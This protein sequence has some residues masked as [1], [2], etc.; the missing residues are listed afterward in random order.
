MPGE[1]AEPPWLELRHAPTATAPAG[2]S[3]AAQPP[4][5]VT[6]RLGAHTVPGL[7]ERV[8][9]LD[10][11]TVVSTTRVRPPVDAGTGPVELRLE[12]WTRHPAAPTV[13]IFYRRRQPGSRLAAPLTRGS[14]RL[15]PS[16]IKEAKMT[17]PEATSVDGDVSGGPAMPAAAPAGISAT[18]DFG[19]SGAVAGVLDVRSVQRVD[20]G[21]LPA[22]SLARAESLLGLDQPDPAVDRALNIE[23][24]TRD[25]PLARAE[26][27]K[28]VFEGP[29][30]RFN[31]LKTGRHRSSDLV[32]DGERVD[33]A[34]EVTGVRLRHRGVK[35]F[36]ADLDHRLPNTRLSAREVFPRIYQRFADLTRDDVQLA[37][38]VP[39]IHV[40]F[41]TKLPP[42]RRAA[43]LDELRRH[44]LAPLIE[45][46]VDESAAAAGFFLMRRFGADALLGAEAFKLHARCP[47]GPRAWEDP[48]LW[49][50]A[51]QWHE[52]LLVIDVGG[53]TTDCA[54]VK[55]VLTDVTPPAAG[56]CPGRFHRLAPEVLASGGRLHLGG[57]LLT[58]EIF[59]LLKERLGIATNAT[60]F[61]GLDDTKGAQRRAVFDALWNA[62][63]AVK[64]RGLRDHAPRPVEIRIGGD[65]VTGGTD[66]G[67]TDTGDGPVRI[68][69]DLVPDRTAAA[70]PVVIT[71]QELDGIISPIV[72]QIA[73]LAAGIALG[74]LSVR[75]QGGQ[76]VDRVALSG[77]SMLAEAL[78]Y[79]VE[80]ALRARF[81]ADGL[82][83]TFEVE[84]DAVHCKTGTAL[85]GMYLNAMAD[86][87]PGDPQSQEVIEQLRKGASYFGVDS[88]RLHV[89]LAAD[90]AL[91]QT[92]QGVAAEPIFRR[93]QPLAGDGDTAYAESRIPYPLVSLINVHRYDVPPLDGRGG[94][95][96]EADPSV[97][98]SYEGVPQPL[99][100]ELTRQGV[101]MRFEINQ[102]E[103]LT[104]ILAKGQ[105]RPVL[106]VPPLPLQ[107]P[108]PDGLVRD[109]VLRYALH[110]D[111]VHQG[112]GI[113]D[114]LV[115]DAQCPVPD[116]GIV[117]PISGVRLLYRQQTEPASAPPGPPPPTSPAAPGYVL[118]LEVPAG[119]RWLSIDSNGDLRTHRERP[120]PHTVDSPEDL[121]TAPEGY[122]FRTE[123]T[124]RLDYDPTKDP[125][126]GIH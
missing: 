8:D 48:R 44:G 33:F 113:F 124:S 9:L 104:L 31:H 101:T 65:P 80:D 82:D 4:G 18:L 97:W 60:V 56:D 102:Q 79:R 67:G 92:I 72:D 70:S 26:A 40:T 81:D 99:V 1:P 84:F 85:G 55:T 110:H 3:A 66:T 63:Q 73:S 94:E 90:F 23:M 30:L 49:D 77:G 74:G 78:R 95:G 12:P 58:L 57:D 54:L 61:E 117:L 106:D 41:P 125:F 62:A 112:A 42:D 96:T 114:S 22:D 103:R 83:S 111:V 19:T 36:L 75:G 17:Q 116:G 119:H 105:P 91:L 87:A 53:G 126:S 120:L 115:V 109:G 21:S 69:A 51:Q 29:P 59:R 86:L 11:T 13:G 45:M 76:S 25:D 123:L 24:E 7:I 28:T 10:G 50:A 88:S 39:R 16:Q 2:P 27:W 64:H 71:A 68:P 15:H 34:D 98:G 32:I 108:P 118:L 122:V 93:G 38:P 6:L 14:F 35:R 43:V 46:N 47:D 107:D 37:V 52:N 100:G 5:T 20:D 89:N 121:L